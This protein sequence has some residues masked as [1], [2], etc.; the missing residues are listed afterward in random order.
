MD[1][2]LIA[3]IMTV[4]NRKEK[5]MRCLENLAKQEMPDR[6]S[7]EVWLT[8]DGCS[9]GTREAVTNAYPTI[10]IID[11]DGNL[12]WN[13]GMLKAWD[14]AS[15]HRRY[16]FYLW[17]NDDI[18][19]YSDAIPELINVS[20]IH[21]NQCVIVGPT[22]SYNHSGVTYGGFIHH[23]MVTPMGNPVKVDYFNGNIV[24]IPDYVFQKVGNLD[25]YYSHGHGDTDYGL[26]VKEIGIESYITGRFL[27]E[28][29]RH[30]KVKKCWDPDVPI[31]DRYI[32]L[33]QPIGYPPCE[34]FYFQ[35]KHFGIGPAILH[36][37]KLY[38]RVSFPIL[39]RW[40]GKENA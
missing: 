24:L 10:N 15:K 9:D 2:I 37:L 12:F 22:Q 20:N 4:H 25:P 17:L 31:K 8:D 7:Y 16:D 1:N 29:D 32:N 39:W 3:V 14:A 38:A 18:S 5:T 36:S 21:N 27:G 34:D 6:Y 13:R 26:R 19:L 28:C 30:T 35:R 23:K 40:L 11:G 33:Y